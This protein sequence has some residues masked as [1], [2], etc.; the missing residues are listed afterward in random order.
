MSFKNKILGAAS[1]ILLVVS[2]NAGVSSNETVN[3]NKTVVLEAPL[4]NDGVVHARMTQSDANT[5][6]DGCNSDK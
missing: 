2:A 3:S 6:C 4:P 5:P 1:F